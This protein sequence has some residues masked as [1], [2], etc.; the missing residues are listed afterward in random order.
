MIREGEW[1]CP[2]FK[3]CH[4]PEVPTIIPLDWLALFVGLWFLVLWFYVW[5]V[6]TVDKG[7]KT[8]G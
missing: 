7:G 3:H 2:L 6:E 4:P 8:D 1:A 5:W